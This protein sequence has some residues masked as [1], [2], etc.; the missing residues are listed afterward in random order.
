MR[1]ATP[2]PAEP[3]GRPG[4]QGHLRTPQAALSRPLGPSLARYARVGRGPHARRPPAVPPRR[5][6]AQRRDPRRRRRHRLAT[7]QA[8]RS[9]GSSATGSPGPTPS[10]PG[11]PDR[12]GPRPHSPRDPADPDRPGV[13]GSATVASPDY[14]RARAAVAILG[15]YS[16]ARLFTEVREKRGL[17]YSVYASY[18]SHRDRAAV[19]LSMPAPRPNEPRRPSTSPSPRSAGS[20][21]RGRRR[22]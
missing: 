2:E 7:A 9:A 12:T 19:T 22:A 11:A 6:P 5:L 4:N 20:A 17:C 15:G 21:G 10:R 3:G 1:L 13:P 8:T 18:E 14:Y 16:S